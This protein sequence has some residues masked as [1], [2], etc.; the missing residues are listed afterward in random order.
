MMNSSEYFPMDTEGENMPLLGQTSEVA[1]SL[2]GS[3]KSSCRVLQA[4]LASTSV[5]PMVQRIREDMIHY[6][7]TP[8]TYEALTSP[9][10]TYTL[11]R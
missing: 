8:L 4:V 10:M 9:D 7:D 1:K 11:V 6:I 3:C 5:Y 2:F